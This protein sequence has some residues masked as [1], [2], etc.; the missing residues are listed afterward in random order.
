MVMEGDTLEESIEKDKELAEQK[1]RADK[2]QRE[3]KLQKYGRNSE[4]KGTT[5]L[6]NELQEEKKLRETAEKTIA[7]TAKEMEKLFEI[8][9][10]ETTFKQ[11]L[12]KGIRTLA[13][14]LRKK[15][16]KGE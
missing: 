6:I 2:L 12:M 14:E 1:A 8:G 3:L 9:K 7:E 11:D 15:E 16:A 13:K 5:K 4:A 10:Q